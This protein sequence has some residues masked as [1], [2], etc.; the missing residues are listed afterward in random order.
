VTSGPQDPRDSQEK[1]ADAGNAIGSNATSSDATSSNATSSDEPPIAPP[2]A[3][4]E[5]TI[6]Q[7]RACLPEY[8]VKGIVGSGAMGVVYEA[9][10]KPLQRRV[11]LKVLPPGLAAREATIQRFLREAAVVARIHHENIV[12]IYDVGSRNGLHY[13]AMRFV[14]GVSLD[15]AVAVAPL[16]PKEVAEI[17][18]SIARALAFAHRQGIVHRDVKPANILREPDGRVVL[19]DFGLARVEGSGTMTESGA[20]VGTPNYMSPE[21][22]TGSRDSVDGRSDVFSLG[23]TLFELLTGKPP[24]EEATTPNTLRAI[25]EKPTPRLKKL[26]P[27]CPPSLE[28]ILGKAMRKDPNDRYPNALALAEDLERYLAGEPILARRESSIVRGARYMKAY[29]FSI[30]LAFVV[31]L[32]AGALILYLYIGRQQGEMYLTR[33]RQKMDTIS[34][35]SIALIRADLDAA[36]EYSNTR[37]SACMERASFALRVGQMELGVVEHRTLV[38]LG[39][40]DTNELL[41]TYELVVEERVEILVLRGNLGLRLGEFQEAHT[42]AQKAMDLGPKNA[43]ALTLAAEVQKELGRTTYD[44]GELSDARSQWDLARDLAEKAIANDSAFPRAHFVRAAVLHLMEDN[45]AADAS[46]KEAK[47]LDPKNAEFRSVYATF[48]K[49]RGNQASANQELEFAKALNPF[50]SFTTSTP[51]IG[52]DVARSM[53]KYGETLRSIIGKP[54]GRAASQPSTLPAS[55]PVKSL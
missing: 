36:H 35:E 32:A 47:R 16:S 22:I 30:A 18:S 15:R 14:P 4:F 3:T 20:L 52:D 29:R 45:D 33:A 21:Q 12:P 51:L 2:G 38:E 5:L 13:L 25:L 26:R 34:A 41:T 10:H 54:D 7:L 23:V 44:R 39:F 55:R 40:K 24:F 6:E 8:D 48:E 9:H 19:T 46:F 50:A 31:L 11:A 49:E 17:G 43:K 42:C 28:V 53:Q 37:K 1:R 27:D